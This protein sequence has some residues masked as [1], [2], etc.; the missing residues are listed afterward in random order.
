MFK[1]TRSDLLQWEK[2]HHQNSYVKSQPGSHHAGFGISGYHKCQGF[3]EIGEN[4]WTR[5]SRIYNHGNL[6]EEENL[7]S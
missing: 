5:F 1:P 4:G 6:I 7:D 2:E 3:R